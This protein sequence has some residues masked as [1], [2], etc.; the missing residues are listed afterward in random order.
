MVVR[1]PEA[2]NN[3]SLFLLKGN[4]PF[5]SFLHSSHHH[6][7]CCTSMLLLWYWASLL[8]PAPPACITEGGWTSLLSFDSEGLPATR[9]GFLVDWLFKPHLTFPEIEERGE[10]KKAER[11][12]QI[13]RNKRN[14]CP[15]VLSVVLCPSFPPCE[16][17]CGFFV[18]SPTQ[19]L[20]S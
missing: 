5:P 12:K 15:Q 9:C 13:T 11:T 18:Y 14:S 10:K 3:V 2:M 20:S 8:T 19:N 17:S 1:F 6:L 16:I 7:V 4:S